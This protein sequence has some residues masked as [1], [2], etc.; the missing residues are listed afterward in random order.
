MPKQILVDFPTFEEWSTE[1]GI[2]EKTR[3]E[4][5]ENFPK[6]GEACQMCRQIQYYILIK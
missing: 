2:L 6:F 5:A 1:N 4:R 3:C